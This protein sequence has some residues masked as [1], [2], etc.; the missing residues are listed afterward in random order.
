MSKLGASIEKEIRAAIPATLFFLWLFHMIALTKAVVIGDHSF[1]G[2]RAAAATVA[3]IIVAKAILIVEHLPIAKLFSSKLVLSVLWKTLLFGT[4][5][6]FFR[7]I[8]QLVPLISKHESLGTAIERFSVDISWPEF[9]VF[10][11]WL[12]SALLIF[13]F[14]SEV[15]H[16]I[17]IHEVKKIVFGAKPEAAKE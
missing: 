4:V 16:K 10:Q 3:A 1:T 12:F 7:L 17:G 5:A 9:W 11:T 13:C 14:V 15:A 6:L 2:L 8:E